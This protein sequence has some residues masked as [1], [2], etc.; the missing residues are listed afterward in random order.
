MTY[1]KGILGEDPKDILINTAYKHDCK[2]SEIFFEGLRIAD[3]AWYLALEKAGIL[4]SEELLEALIKLK[5]FEINPKYG[6]IYNSKNIALKKLTKDAKN[7]HISRPRREAINIAFYL[8]LKNRVYKLYKTVEKLAFTFLDVAQR[9]KNLVMSDYTYLQQ[10]QPTTFGHYIL[11][12]LFPLL[13]DIDRLE[14]FYKHLNFSPAGSGSVNGV[15]FDID[16]EYLAKLLGFKEVEIHTRDSM[17]RSDLAIEGIYVL[18]SIMANINRVVDEFQIFVSS[19]FDLIKLPASLSRASVIM[20]NKQNPYALTYIRGVSNEILGKVVSFISYEKIFSGN[21]DSRTFVYVDLISSF[22]KVIGALELFRVVLEEIEVKEKKLKGYFWATDVADY[23]VEKYGLSYE[24]AHDEVGRVVRFMR[25]NN[26]KEVKSEFFKYE[27]PTF[28]FEAKDSI[29]RK[30]GVGSVNDLENI[31]IN[32]RKR[33]KREIIDNDFS[34]LE[35]ELKERG[36]EVK[37]AI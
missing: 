35:N 3:I 14:L 37:F 17:W 13:R 9:Y 15:T 24:D 26:I 6:D 31:I 18:S 29:K 2:G 5:E 1:G 20:P 19:E 27:I 22:D 11:T 25:E 30:K 10:A 8:T 4:K 33:I 34:F 32:A 36:Y 21:P 28:L 16:R 7:I 12:F 23:L